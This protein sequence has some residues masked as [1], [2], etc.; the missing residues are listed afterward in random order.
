MKEKSIQFHFL[1]FEGPEELPDEDLALLTLAKKVAKNAYAPYSGFRVGAAVLLEDGQM[2]AS[3][4]YENASYPLGTCAERSVLAAAHAQHPDKKVLAM[5]I[6]VQND[7]MEIVQPAAP[8]G[9]CRQNILETERK[10]HQ[11]MRVIM[12]GETGPVYV[13]EKGADLL[14]L[15][16]DETYL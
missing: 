7:S 11:P 15:A 1:E 10:N 14:P 13:V 12:H 8:C 5:A 9:G 6:A 4:N 2:L 3:T 16:F